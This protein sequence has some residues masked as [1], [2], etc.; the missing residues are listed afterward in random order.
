MSHHA[1]PV[2][3]PPDYD[4]PDNPIHQPT[5]HANHTA[6]M[7]RGARCDICPLGRV[8]N[9]GPVPSTVVA[10]AK[11][12]IAGEAA[13]KTELLEKR[14]FVGP[15][16]RILNESL[17]TGG[18]SRSQC[19]IINSI[20]CKPPTDY[21]EYIKQLT[22]EHDRRVI[23]YQNA[24]EAN[25]DAAASL[26]DPGPLLL[27]EDCCRPRFVRDVEESNSKVS[28]A[29]GNHALKAFA[30]YFDIPFGKRKKGQGTAT[31]AKTISEQHGAP[32]TL[33]DGRILCSAIH[34]ASAMRASGRAMMPVI[35]ADLAR[36]ARIAVRGYVDWVAPKSII[37]PSVEVIE[38][39][40][41]S[42]VASNSV[43]CV[44]IETNGKD[45]RKCQIRCIGLGAVVDGEE[46]VIVVPF[47]HRQGNLEWWPD[48]DTKMRVVRAV[49]EVLDNCNL[50]GHNF[51]N[52]DSTVLLRFGLI[53]DRT[54]SFHDTMI[55][56][57][58]SDLCELPKRLEFVAV[59]FLEIFTWKIGH[60][61]KYDADTGIGSD[62]E[63]AFY[64]GLD[65]SSCL[66]IY[67]RLIDR[68]AELGTRN[69]YD[70]DMVL[71][72]IFRE[73]G[74]LGLCV[75]T[76]RR[77]NIA[78]ILRDELKR[79]RQALIEVL[80]DVRYFKSGVV[81]PEILEFV[82]HGA[83][84]SGNAKPK[85]AKKAKK[86]VAKP[87]K[88]KKASTKPV[89]PK[90]AAK[91]K[92]QKRFN[93]NTPADISYFLY[94]IKKLIPLVNS[95]GRDF[96]DGDKTT[97][98]A[99]AM[100]RLL[101]NGVDKQTAD[102]I[103]AL[104]VYRAY[105][106]LS[107]TYAG[108]I[109]TKDIKK[110]GV[111]VAREG[112]LY[113]GF[114]MEAED[115]SEFGYAEP[116][117]FLHT[118]YNLSQIASG[119]V[120]TRPAVQN[121]L[122]RGRETVCYDCL[123]NPITGPQYKSC[124]D[125]NKDK[126]KKDVLWNGDIIHCN[127]CHAE[128]CA[129]CKGDGR[130]W[131]KDTA[132]FIDSTVCK[133]CGAD[134]KTRA[135]LN[136]RAMIKAPPGHV[137][138]DADFAGLE[139]RIYAAVAQDQILLDLLKTDTD[140]HLFNYA[141][142]ESDNLDGAWALY[143]KYEEMGGKKHPK[144]KFLRTVAK[145]VC[146]AEGQLVLTHRGLVPIETV[147]N[148]D[149]LWDGL[150]WVSHDGV[151][152]NGIREVIDYDGLRATSDHEV[153]LST[154]EKTTFA[155]AQAS[156]TR[157]A[158]SGDGRN[159]LRFVDD[160]QPC[161]E[162][163][164]V[165]RSDCSM[166]E[167][168]NR[169]DCFVGQF[170]GRQ[171]NGM[172]SLHAYAELG[173]KQSCM[174][175]ATN[176]LSARPM[177]ESERSAVGP[178][179]R[180]RD[181]IPIR[182]HRRSGSLDGGQSWPPRQ[183]Y[184]DRPRQQRRAL[185]ARQSSLGDSISELYESLE[186]EAPE[187]LGV[188]SGG[189]ALWKERGH[190]KTFDGRNARTDTSDST[191]DN[192]TASQELARYQKKIRVYDI[193]NAG[194][195]HRFTVS[196]CLVSNCFAI[197]YGCEVEPDNKLYAVLSAERDKAT[198]ERVFPDDKIKPSDCVRWYRNWYATHPWTKPWQLRMQRN[199]EIYGSVASVLDGRKRM[200]SGGAEKKNAPSNHSIQSSAADCANRAIIGIAKRIPFRAWSPLSGIV[201]QVH[202]SITVVV[203]E[204]RAEEAKR[205]IEEEMTMYV[206]GVKIE[207]EAAIGKYWSD[208]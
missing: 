18:L 67:Y 172:P 95:K 48:A 82:E 25:P 101:S 127:T 207:A 66:R 2:L 99:G 28:L 39:V 59:R 139:L 79:R 78:T 57:K 152:C 202:D 84:S 42:L 205:I 17:Q 150:E 31:I 94:K 191:R 122:S 83:P 194:P 112:D 131:D 163:R 109:A 85:K 201:L 110:K 43:V 29:V 58:D 186:F 178:L 81:P 53:S 149:L 165:L 71:A 50:V 10:N 105:E 16:G 142:L 9:A 155:R 20:G 73:M 170:E 80:I 138:V 157:I 203:P 74:L 96:K 86:V 30:R 104:F 141:C 1:L 98:S 176:D 40:C 113:G 198:G 169:E 117:Y 87:A 24:C 184:G 68:M 47:R 147:R 182:F 72:P 158:R 192:Q 173:T 179:W 77:R 108:R 164:Q 140:L 27:P 8:A 134:G 145:R 91:E 11:L 23:A 56:A 65:V 44:D 54:R 3:P 15:S 177:H 70:I 135:P 13:G 124:K 156:R 60:D 102:F 5:W 19:S 189:V 119:R 90:K 89:K 183:V 133:A 45:P 75:D 206:C 167:V 14:N 180:S 204:D 208:V 126:R 162:G 174:A 144:L 199:A 197:L 195:R 115:W 12:T 103:D 154:G 41:A 51:V 62:E 143:R 35:K 37:F 196:D 136:M 193:L 151:I 125:C 148:T 107:S 132:R 63:L 69:Q 166:H 146:I 200:F 160:T 21:N 161:C 111:V 114:P 93:P 76:V 22:R 190:G 34:P 123:G 175:P 106:K 129:F 120:S 118:T 4:D 188:H 121:W 7:S 185:R 171:V 130:Q 187:R 97:S 137:L 100:L 38:R 6:A 36:A 55:A 181:R 33:R 61:D 92:K 168:R 49:R 46:V 64:C 128:K 159:P 32:I 88:L 26:R 116:L 52:F 153:W